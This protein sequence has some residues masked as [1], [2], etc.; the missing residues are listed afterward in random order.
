MKKAM[1]IENFDSIDE[2]HGENSLKSRPEQKVDDGRHYTHNFFKKETKAHFK[3]LD[4]KSLAEMAKFS[5]P[6]FF[7]QNIVAKQLQTDVIAK[8]PQVT[9]N[10]QKFDENIYDN[11]PMLVKDQNL[12]KKK[13]GDKEKPFCEICSKSFSRNPDLRRHLKIHTGEKPFVC[14]VCKKTF[15]QRYHLKR[16]L[17]MQ[18]DQ[19]LEKI[20]Q[21][22]LCENGFE[23]KYNLERHMIAHG[24]IYRFAC[25]VCGKTF[26]TKRNMQE[27]IMVHHL[28]KKSFQCTICEKNFARK[29]H[30][31]R[32]L[33]MHSG[34]KPYV[35][36]IFS[37][38][39]ITQG[40]L[41]AHQQRI[42]LK[43]RKYACGEC[44]KHFF[45]KKCLQT[46]LVVHTGERPYSCEICSKS[47]SIQANLNSHL[48]VHTGDKPYF[49]KVCDCSYARGAHLKRHLKAHPDHMINT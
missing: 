7:N 43:E 24:D 38:S 37:R 3:H 9:V 36:D 10:A 2:I 4:I 21:C 1:K 22:G 8:L 11:R 47:F 30:L 27:H 25:E 17:K 26:K 5:L 15:R 42:H 48:H 35:C 32:H 19:E 14:D 29:D 6:N 31:N 34:S 44:G 49:C 41:K 40:N 33:L 23:S 28:G 45:S 20:F 12:L 39:F 18:H 16:H 46:H 13:N